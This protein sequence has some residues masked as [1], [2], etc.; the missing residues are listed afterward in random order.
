MVFIVPPFSD[1]PGAVANYFVL[2]TL[3]DWL[4]DQPIQRIGF[5]LGI[6]S[7]FASTRA[8]AL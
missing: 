6:S 3:I 2:P 8:A 4:D 1:V 7:D 5:A